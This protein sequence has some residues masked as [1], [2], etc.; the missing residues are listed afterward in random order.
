[1]TVFFISQLEKD[2]S[3]LEHCIV[4]EKSLKK[5]PFHP[6]HYLVMQKRDKSLSST[7]LGI[8]ITQNLGNSNNLSLEKSK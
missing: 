8:H 5:G 3:D 1:M 6:T 4:P 2:C 7:L